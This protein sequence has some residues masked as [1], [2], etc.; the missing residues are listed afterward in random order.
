MRLLAKRISD[1]VATKCNRDRRHQSA[2]L[3][4]PSPPTC[5]G[6]RAGDEGAGSRICGAMQECEARQGPSPP[7]PLPINGERGALSDLCKDQGSGGRV[8]V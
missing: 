6:R 7:A 4:L 8:H 5:W 3:W 2:L 1:P